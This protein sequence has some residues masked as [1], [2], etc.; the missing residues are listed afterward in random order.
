MVS[1]NDSVMDPPRGPDTMY[2]PKHILN[3]KEVKDKTIRDSDFKS[4]LPNVL[5]L[6][7]RGT[8]LS[9]ILEMERKKPISFENA[10]RLANE[11]WKEAFRAGELEKC[12]YYHD[13]F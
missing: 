3:W 13:H 6:I 8:L 11:N 9:K 12:N 5:D 7:Y 4:T 1:L 2:M 10:I